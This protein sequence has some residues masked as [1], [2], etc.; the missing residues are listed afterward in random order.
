MLVKGCITKEF[1]ERERERERERD[2]E[3]EMQWIHA[4][5]GPASL[6]RRHSP[7]TSPIKSH[8]QFIIVE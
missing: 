7:S 1:G 2:T 6:E 8:V 3:R 5:R 4:S